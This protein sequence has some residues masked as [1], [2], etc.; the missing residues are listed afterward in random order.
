MPRAEIVT[1]LAEYFGED[2]V[3]VLSLAGLSALD[4]APAE[5]RAEAATLLRRLYALK[6]ADRFAIL[7]Q[8]NEILDFLECD[9]SGAEHPAALRRAAG[10]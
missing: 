2:P 10:R 4:A 9:P 8:L 6:P 3:T 5:A 1:E 7:K